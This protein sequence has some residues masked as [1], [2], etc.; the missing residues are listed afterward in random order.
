MVRFKWFW[1]FYITF[2]R[3]STM[4]LTPSGRLSTFLLLTTPCSI[5]FVILILYSFAF[6]LMFIYF[7]SNLILSC[8]F[9]FHL[10]IFSS[11]LFSLLF[12][13]KL[14]ATLANNNKS[15]EAI[16]VYAKALSERPT[17]AR[18]WLN[19]GM[20]LQDSTAVHW[21]VLFDRTILS[22]LQDYSYCINLIFVLRIDQLY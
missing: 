17:Y 20:T 14:G 9:L 16:Q 12:F 2:L 5:R 18:G 21:E 22:L 4:L 15:E 11:F 13:M 1:V 3:T 8:P 19:L 7:F 10:S 6:P